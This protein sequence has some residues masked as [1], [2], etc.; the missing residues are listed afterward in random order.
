[1][2]SFSEDEIMRAL[3]AV[4]L[5]VFVV[6]SAGQANAE[7]PHKAWWKF[8]KGDWTYEIPELNQKATATWRIAAKGNALV[9]RFEESDG[10]VAIE[11]A[12]YR[13]DTKTM[14]VSGYS[15]RGNYWH[16]D[17][18]FVEGVPEGLHHGMLPDGRPFKGRFKVK[19]VDE[20]HF[21][22]QMEGKAG[23]SEQFAMSGKYERKTK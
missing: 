18:K 4:L 23:D 17:L 8:I 22:W 5:S 2:R 3:T 21:E 15:S 9:G 19:K 20:N 16:L 12:G 10:T 7:E 13:A 1:M 11:L 6:A 14:V